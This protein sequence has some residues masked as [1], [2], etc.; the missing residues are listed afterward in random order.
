MAGLGVALPSVCVAGKG[1]GA[2]EYFIVKQA[3][4]SSK[5]Y[6][7]R[8][9]DSRAHIS[10]WKQETE[11]PGTA[12]HEMVTKQHMLIPITIASAAIKYT[13]AAIQPR[14]WYNFD[15]INTEQ[16]ARVTLLP[17]NT[18]AETTRKYAKPFKF[19]PHDSTHSRYYQIASTY[20]QR[21]N[22]SRIPAGKKY[23]QVY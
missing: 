15:R 14:G 5:N 9:C 3:A 2:A 22:A 17:P 1:L 12:A 16:D 4:S 7:L 8:H 11:T 20:F 19:G 13:C 23:R 10:N 21:L 6:T 18:P